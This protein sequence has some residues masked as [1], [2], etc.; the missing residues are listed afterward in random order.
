MFRIEIDSGGEYDEYAFLQYMKF[1]ITQDGADSVLNCICLQR[2]TGD[3]VGYSVGTSQ[4]GKALKRK[5]VADW[6]GVEQLFTIKTCV[7]VVKGTTGYPV[8]QRSFIGRSIAF[9]E[10]GLYK[11]AFGAIMKRIY[12]EWNSISTP[13]ECT[14]SRLQ[15]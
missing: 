15:R 11:K 13:Q 12:G 14:Y 8:L 6:F 2:S 7:T 3:E 4:G 10:I 5:R 9:T 1:T